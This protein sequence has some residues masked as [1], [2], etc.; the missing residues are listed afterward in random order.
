MTIADNYNAQGPGDAATKEFSEPPPF[1]DSWQHK[2]GI[3]VYESFFI[4]DLM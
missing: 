1:Y 2:E 3:P 4:E